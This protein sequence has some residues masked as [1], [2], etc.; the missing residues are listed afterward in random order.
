MLLH[1]GWAES[2]SGIDSGALAR[3]AQT[4]RDKNPTTR[5]VDLLA[6]GDYWLDAGFAYPYGGGFVAFLLRKFSASQFVDIYNR[7]N[8]STLD[9]DFRVVYGM[10]LTELENASWRDATAIASK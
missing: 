10:S 5:I 8:V 6:P 3:R 7:C 4:A 2:Q 9:S 1:E